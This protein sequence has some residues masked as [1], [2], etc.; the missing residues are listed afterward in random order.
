MAEIVT[1]LSEDQMTAYATIITGGEE[2]ISVDEV[3]ERLRSEGVIFG[4]DKEAIISAINEKNL[5]KQFIAARGK[6]PVPG[7]DT[8]LKPMFEKKKKVS[9]TAGEEGEKIDYKE[10]GLI[11]NVQAKTVLMLKIPPTRGIP[12]KTIKGEIIPTTDG[13][14]KP[15]PLGR[16]TS[17]SPDSLQ[18]I[19][20]IDG[21]LVFE[22]DKIHVDTVYETSSDV[23]VGTGNL[24]VYGDIIVNGDVLPRYSLKAT[25]NIE[26]RGTVGRA[27]LEAGGDILIQNGI[28]G[29]NVGR[30][31]AKGDIRTKFIE[32]ANVESEHDIFVSEGI[33]HSNVDANGRIIVVEGK[34]GTII[35]GRIR[36]RSEVNAKVIGS[37]NE[38]PTGVEVGISPQAREEAAKLEE[39]IEEGKKEFKEL[40]LQIKTLLALK[41]KSGGSLSPDKEKMLV[42]RLKSQNTL[43]VDLK[44]ATTRL[45][46]LH[47]ELL[48]STGGK[49]CI[50][51]TVYPKSKFSLHTSTLEIAREAKYVTYVSRAGEIVTLV[52]EE[53]RLEK[54]AG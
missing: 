13:E 45:A 28:K 47:K 51:D 4:I 48:A 14:D 20:N 54:K 37:W 17:L 39:E 22:E 38:T 52:Y 11:Q 8:I 7:K 50:F 41:D 25:G 21:F 42:E 10:L 27:F 12:G 3:E 1:E 24:E 34:K 33:L 32:N 18:L 40:R 30:V 5:N 29:K 44:K 19:A 9:F 43:M 15:I 49:I 2:T 16:N 31:K 53:P 46:Q 35:G 36:A 26:V 23:G 6:A